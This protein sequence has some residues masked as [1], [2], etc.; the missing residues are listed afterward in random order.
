MSNVRSFCYFFVRDFFADTFSEAAWCVFG[1]SF[2][3]AVILSTIVS[4][5]E[6]RQR[7]LM[8]V[9]SNYPLLYVLNGPCSTSLSS[10]SY[11]SVP[12]DFSFQAGMRMSVYWLVMFIIHLLIYL[13]SILLFIVL[14]YAIGEFDG[15]VSDNF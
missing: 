12:T 13:L 4:E 8:K 14:G 2:Y 1:P 11:I 15:F 10:P 9:V 5:K 3:M 6:H 7:Y